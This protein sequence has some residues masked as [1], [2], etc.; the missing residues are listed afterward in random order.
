MGYPQPNF[1]AASM[2]LIDP[3]PSSYARTASSKY[4]T[5]RRF[6][7]KP[8]LSLVRTGVFPSFLPNSNTVSYTS[9][10]V[11]IVRITSTS[12][13][14]GTGLKKCRPTN[15]SGR[16]VAVI[17]SV[18]EM[19]E[20]L[21]A[22]IAAGF[23]IGSSEANILRFSSRFSMMA[24][25]MMSQA[26]RSSFFVVPCNREKIMSTGSFNAPLAEN[27]SRDF[28]IPAKPLSMYFRSISRDTTSNPAV[29]Q[30]WAIPDPIRPQPNTPTFSILNIQ[31]SRDL[32]SSQAPRVTWT[33]LLGNLRVN[34]QR[35]IGAHTRA[36]GNTRTIIAQ[37]LLP[38]SGLGDA[39][40]GNKTL[41]QVSWLA[42]CGPEFT[43]PEHHGH[44]ES[45][46]NLLTNC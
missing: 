38:S 16:L 8:V 3:T 45:C 5:N 13:I 32:F 24:S 31:T 11:A 39:A 21:L 10:A 28:R 12:F 2:S 33:P 37:N 20:V 9:S 35:K 17:V 42:M 29:A 23:A 25:M 7:M 1:I 22:K 15:R 46:Y 44:L 43:L 30:T 40:R 36:W 6:T 14:S 4:G 18:M 19:E 41:R 27:L 34:V 26:A